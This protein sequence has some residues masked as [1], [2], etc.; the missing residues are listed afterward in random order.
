MQ[1]GGSQQ[2]ISENVFSFFVG[3]TLEGTTYDDAGSF[4]IEVIPSNDGD[5][6]VL[7]VTVNVIA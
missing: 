1:V 5:L 4:S 3:S 2:Y 6:E 7:A